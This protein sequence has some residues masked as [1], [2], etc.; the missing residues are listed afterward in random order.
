MY[1]GDVFIGIHVQENAESMYTGLRWS[2]HAME[3]EII[4]CIGFCSV[5]TL[6]PMATYSLQFF[7]AQKTKEFQ[8][9]I[10]NLKKN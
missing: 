10:L 2:L 4:I 3:T 1:S 8:M 6:W 5:R 7:N 9:V